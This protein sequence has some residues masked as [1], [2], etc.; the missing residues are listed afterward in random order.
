MLMTL[1]LAFVLLFVAGMTWFHGLWG[2][3][4]TLVNLLFAAMVATSFYE[5]ISSAIVKQLTSYSYLVDFLTIWGLFALTFGLMRLITDMLSQRRLKFHPHVETAGR[6]ILALLVGYLMMMFT[7]MTLHTAPIQASPFNVAWQS[8]SDPT[9]LGMRPDEQWMGLV[10]GQSKMGL[11]GASV[12]DENGDF[13]RR[14]FDR[15]RRLESEETFL[16]Q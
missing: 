3:F 10:R 11:K 9:F 5:P 2:N 7:S 4:L 1:F 15:R 8:P 13:I 16:V 14:H 6:S 12:F